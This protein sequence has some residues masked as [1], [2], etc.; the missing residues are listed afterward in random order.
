[1]CAELDSKAAEIRAHAWSV[2]TWKTKCSQWKK[3]INFCAKSASPIL[4]TSVQT[5]CRYIVYL[6]EDLKY[7]TIDNYVSAVLA[8]NAHYGYD[9][10]KIR[11]DFVFRSTMSGLR[12]ILGDP[13][14]IR[15]TLTVSQLLCM[16]G[17]M[18]ISDVNARAMWTCIVT[19]FRTLLRKSNLVPGSSIN[20][21]PH[22][23]RRG[24]V[25][26]AEWGMMVTVSSSKTIQ[27]GQRLHRIPVAYAHG[28]PLCAVKLLKAHFKDVP[29]SDPNSPAFLIRLRGKTVPLQYPRLLTF[30]K[31]LLRSIGM[32]CERAG[33]HSLRRSGAAFMHACGV[34]LEDIR[35]TGDW[36]SLSALI[37]LA[38]PI[39][40]RIL[41]DCAVSRA[42]VAAF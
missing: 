33:V 6:S 15:V 19:S 28:S 26:F 30:L 24:A 1:M 31:G 9:V 11:A 42:I 14:P 36:A 13:T 27:Y 18:D 22:Y 4:P 2:T 10:S 40:S 25:T 16:F 32:D 41:T 39:S 34:P 20:L 17:F 21:S 5:M 3:Y 8:L 23:L 12:R 35:Y 38:K 29:S 37:Y 7:V